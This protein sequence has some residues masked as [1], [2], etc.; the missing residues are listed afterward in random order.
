LKGPLET[1]SGGGYRLS[2]V[3]LREEFKLYAERFYDD[4]HD[5]LQPGGIMVGN[6]HYG[7]RRYEIHVDRIRRSFNGV[8]LVVDDSDL[9]NSI[10]F[11]CK[12][13]KLEQHRAGLVR[14]PKGLE[15]AA[16]QHLPAGFALIA[17][18]LKDQGR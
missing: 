17:S 8:V 15:E 3:R 1:P 12:G 10:V 5:A 4:C 14:R 9:S 18:T 16:A 7:H 2:N 13:N 6:L 11:A